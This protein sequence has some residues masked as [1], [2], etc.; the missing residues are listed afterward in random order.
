MICGID[1]AGRGPILG[2][3]VLCGVLIKEEDEKKLI[4]IKVKDSKLLTSEQREDL[5]EKIKDI[6]HSYEIFIVEPKE[7]D[8]AVNGN[9]GL[10]LNWLE[11]RKSALVINTLKPDTAIVDAPSPNIGAYKEY[12]LGFLDN[13][14]TKLI[15]EHKADV[16]YPVVAAASILAK[17]TRDREV[18]KI[19]KEIGIDFGSGYLSDPKTAD[20]LK[21]HHETFSHLFRKSWTPYQ[22][23]K[24]KKFQSSLHDFSAY[25]DS[26][27]PKELADQI[28]SLKKLKDHG[29][30][31]IP[32]QSTHEVIRY[33][34]NGTI[35]LYT[36]GKIL[37][38]GNE[39]EKKKIENILG[40]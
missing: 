2:P 20:F 1:E 5:F 39:G 22:D 14:K 27:I 7:I 28:Q 15:L 4:A 29:F 32:T 16:N 33:K 18:D 11:A 26:N 31:P 24:N 30:D 6:A 8:D 12:L 3:L 17:V 34:G 21:S 38:Q 13:K 35:T 40:M 36:T 9:G 37:I 19:K 23:L 25:S 10:N